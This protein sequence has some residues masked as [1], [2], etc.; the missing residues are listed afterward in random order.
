LAELMAAT[1]NTPAGGPAPAAV[2]LEACVTRWLMELC[3]LRLPGRRQPGD[4][5]ERR[6]HGQPDGPRRGPP[7]GRQ[8]RRLEHP[9]GRPPGRPGALHPVCHQGGPFLR[10]QERRGH[11]ARHR[12]SS[13]GAGG[14]RPAPVG[15]GSAWSPRRAP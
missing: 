9:H 13:R 6:I 11:G 4:P 1:V 5:G 15:G 14:R 8:G 2:N 12:Q 3:G 7:L 10:A